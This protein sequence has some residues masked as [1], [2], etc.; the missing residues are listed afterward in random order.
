MLQ[1]Q[2]AGKKKM[3]AIGKVNVPSE[4]RHL[5]TRFAAWAI[6]DLDVLASLSIG[7]L[8]IFQKKDIKYRC[9]CVF[10]C[11]LISLSDDFSKCP[12]TPIR[13]GSCFPSRILGSHPSGVMASKPRG[14]QAETF[15]G[16]W[17]TSRQASR[18]SRIL[19]FAGYHCPP[20]I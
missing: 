15:T 1:K 8:K 2:A 20:E 3:Q 11:F 10:L 19:Q 16:I 12:T 17:T 14:G 5:Q 18:I 13:A 9:W 4:P 6:C 7:S